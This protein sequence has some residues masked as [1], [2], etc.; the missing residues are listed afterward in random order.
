[1]LEPLVPTSAR[2]AEY[3]VQLDAYKLLTKSTL[4]N[5]GQGVTTRVFNSQ[6]EINKKQHMFEVPGAHTFFLP[7]DSS[8]DLSVQ[9][10]K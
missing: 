2:D 1:M 4:Y 7:V 6:A 10:G 3:F 5:L 9:V 8:F